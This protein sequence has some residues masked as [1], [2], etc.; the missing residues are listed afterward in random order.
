M[1]KI[2]FLLFLPFIL[3]AQD[4]YVQDIFTDN[5]IVRIDSIIYGNNIVYPDDNTTPN[6]TRTDLYMNIFMPDT[7]VDTSKSRWVIILTHAGSFLPSNF[8]QEQPS[9]N[10]S[11]NW[12]VEACSSFARKGYVAVAM[13]YRVGW[14]PFAGS[15]EER[16]KSIIQAVWRAQ[17]DMRACVRFFG[18]SVAENGNPYKIDPAKIVTGG[19]SSGGYVALHASI[20][21]DDELMLPK[22]VDGNG[23]P[24]IDTL[25]LG[26]AEGSSGNPGYSSRVKAVFSLGGAVGDTAF[27]DPGDPPFVAVHGTADNTTPYGT[28]LVVTSTSGI[29]IIEVSGSKDFM[30][31]AT[32]L[33][34][35]NILIQVGFKDALDADGILRPGL[36]PY[37]GLGFGFYTWFNG[38]TASEIAT[39]K[40]YLKDV[41]DFAAPRLK[42]ILTDGL[43]NNIR[44]LELP[45]ANLYPHPVISD[46]FLITSD[47]KIRYIKVFSVI[48]QEVSPQKISVTR[49][50]AEVV[51]PEHL[52]GTFLVQ[53]ETENGRIWKKIIVE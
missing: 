51:L 13:T 11:E 4:R 24:F 14:N 42:V 27:Q 46:K 10:L 3:F 19:S 25:L 36:K 47:S 37:D 6:P 17:Q 40:Q 21:D 45:E 34:N 33:G 31:K 35:Q 39:A 23:N 7:S 43:Y 44:R 48:G 26:N 50:Q 41:I 12:L 28:G 49:K 22:F 29:P 9:G 32:D 1:K 8:S 20:L 38:A 5:Q 30:K 53:I 52:Q 2:Y 18:R 15:F 16:S